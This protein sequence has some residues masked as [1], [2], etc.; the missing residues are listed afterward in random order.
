MH[1]E[2]KYSNKKLSSFSNFIFFVV[3]FMFV[4][5][6]CSTLSS[7][8]PF[9]K[10]DTK[11]EPMP[12]VQFSSTMSVK[13]LWKLSVGGSGNFVFSP[14]SIGSNIYAASNDGN[15]YKINALSGQI[16]WK[17]NADMALTAGVG[18]D[19]NS[20]AV[21][22]NKGMLIVFDSNGKLR[23][24][25][26]A[27]SEILSSPVISQGL[28]IVRSIDNRIAAYDVETG[29][30]KWLIERPIPNLT[31][32]I[33]S[34]IAI[35]DQVAIVSSPGGKLLSL[36]VANG[37]MRWEVA[38]ADPKGAT[39]LERIVDVTGTPAIA[40]NN[41][42]SATYQGK[43]GCFDLATGVSRWSKSIS[44]EVG[45]AADERFVFAADSEGNVFGYSIGGGSTVWRNEKLGNRH[46]SAP[47]SYGRSVVLGD[48]FGYLHF[49]SREDG[50]FIARIET[51]GSPILSAPILADQNLVIQTKSGAIVAFATE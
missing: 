35:N 49:L 13:Q 10:K 18:A 25:M 24:K 40:N 5:A 16:V 38:A 51:D 9:S 28:V 44:S 3:P 32:R 22:G 6:G 37:G 7:L 47:T 11:S 48:Q 21:A 43:V 39:E 29:V 8:N 31:L 15:V 36:T 46:L 14:I 20:V 4:M 41:V 19:S 42:C 26:Q 2:I 27:S 12:L 34:G 33:N 45:V 50:A 23:W 1:Q 30:R 17:S